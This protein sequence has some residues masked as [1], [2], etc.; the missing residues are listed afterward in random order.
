M[1]NGFCPCLP[2]TSAFENETSREADLPIR[3]FAGDEA[4][5]IWGRTQR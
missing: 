4:V 2:A 3:K 5:T 1:P